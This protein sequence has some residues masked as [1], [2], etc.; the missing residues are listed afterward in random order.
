MKFMEVRRNQRKP[1]KF[2]NL[3]QKMIKFIENMSSHEF[4]AT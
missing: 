2:M 3:H 1:L 4:F